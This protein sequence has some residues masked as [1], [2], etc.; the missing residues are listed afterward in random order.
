MP[1]TWLTAEQARDIEPHVSCV[2]ALH[3]HSTG[4]IDYAAV[5]RKLAD[6][7]TAQRGEVLLGQQVTRVSETPS[8]VLVATDHDE[9][10]ADLLVNCAGLH[11]DRVA[12]LGGL[13]PDVRIVPFRGE[14]YELDEAHT[15]LVVASSTPSRT[16]TSRSWA[17]T[18]PAAST[19]PCMLVPTPSWQGPVR[20]TPGQRSVVG[21]SS[22]Q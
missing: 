12:Q 19:A 16:P 7:V 4:R 21:T 14:Y 9:F 20:A 8:G 22:T 18:S 6:L 10:H 5:T 2:A 1:S 11:S 13:D 15:D 17:S 3:V